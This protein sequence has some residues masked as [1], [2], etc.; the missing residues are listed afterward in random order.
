MWR[1]AFAL[2]LL[3]LASPA[4]AQTPAVGFMPADD[5][6]PD[7]YVY[8]ARDSRMAGEGR[9][10]QRV[11]AK[12]GNVSLTF[13][14]LVTPDAESAAD[15]CSRLDARSPR[16]HPTEP[17]MVGE[18]AW[19]RVDDIDAHHTESVYFRSGSLCLGIVSDHG[20][21]SY[22]PAE[23]AAMLERLLRSME[24]RASSL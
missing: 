5:E 16:L 18:Q 23:H 4:W 13:R 6:I 11:Y 9:E 14:V 15:A 20:D 17:P 2:F 3:S 12:N 22:D 24:A 10:G 8:Q 19:R 21:G 1:F 7:G